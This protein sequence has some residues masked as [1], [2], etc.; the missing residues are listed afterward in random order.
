MA[1][2]I[3][4]FDVTVTAGTTISSPQTTDLSFVDGIVTDVE[5]VIPDGV[6]GL[7]GIRFAYGGQ[8]IIPEKGDAFIV[9]NNEVVKWPL[10]S[11]PTGKQ[12]QAVTYN[13]DAFDHTFRVRILINELPSPVISNTLPTPIV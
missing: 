10:S 9:S 4:L 5:I 8:T 7:A 11:F 6:V 12:W 3:E 1:D 2:R 13:D